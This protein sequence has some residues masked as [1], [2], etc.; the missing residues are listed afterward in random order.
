MND[1]NDGG[2]M[3]ITMLGSGTSS[4][5]P[6]IGCNCATC[7]SSDPRDKRLRPS[8][9]VEVNSR[10]IVVDT[11]SDFREQCIRWDVD[12]IDAVLYTHH[13]FD[14]IAGFDDLRAFNFTAKKPVPI[15]LMQET[16]ENIQRIFEYAFLPEK[17]LQ[18]S[19]PVVDVNVIGDETFDVFGVPCRVVPLRH[20]SMR[21]NGYRIGQFAYCTDCNEITGEGYEAL[22]GVEYLILDALRYRPHPTHFTLEEAIDVAGKIGARKTWFT[23]IAHD[24][25]HEDAAQ[26]LPENMALGYDGLQI[27]VGTSE[28]VVEKNP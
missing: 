3:R 22:D 2:E 11:S 4:G 5:V 7:L 21:V 6:T 25:R 20:G 14:H 8:I 15:F 19:A 27:T 1:K 13:H 10:V 12:Q 16:L 23:H 28:F 9:L 17:R 26:M 18:S 24:I